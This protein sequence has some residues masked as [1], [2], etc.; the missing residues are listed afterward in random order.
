MSPKEENRVRSFSVVVSQP[1]PRIKS[2]RL[3][4]SASAMER[5]ASRMSGWRRRAGWR[6]SRSWSRVKGLMILR[7]SSRVRMFGGGGLSISAVVNKAVP[8]SSALRFFEGSILLWRE[9]K[10]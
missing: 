10:P 1:R 4:G 2:L 3:A 9:S 5:T 7:A 8:F 6:M